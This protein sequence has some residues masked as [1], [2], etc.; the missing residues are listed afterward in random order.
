MA[1]KRVGR[2]ATGST[3]TK[4]SVTIDDEILASA[5]AVVSRNKGMSLSSLVETALERLLASSSAPDVQAAEL[6]VVGFT[7]VPLL[8]AAAGYPILADAELVAPDRELGEGRFMLEL[9]GDSMEPRFH[10]RQ[11]IVLRDKATLKRPVLKYGEFYCFVHE[12]AATF[13]QWAKDKQSRKV[14]RSLNPEHPDIPADEQTQW[15]GWFDKEDN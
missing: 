9:R 15:I 7:E 11:R 8:R 2:P 12:G 10:D 14:L 1:S 6:R 4:K 5:E 13:K 3:K